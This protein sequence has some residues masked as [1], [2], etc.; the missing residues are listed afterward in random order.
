MTN[1]F[2]KDYKPV[3]DLSDVVLANKTGRTHSKNRQAGM[4]SDDPEVRKAASGTI[5]V[6]SG[7]KPNHRL[8]KP[9]Q[10]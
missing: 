3:V 2:S 7:I 9:S 6:L 4:D 10:M 8:K 5:G 1:A